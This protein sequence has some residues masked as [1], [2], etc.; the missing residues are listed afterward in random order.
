TDARRRHI[1][2]LEK[3]HGGV[4]FLDE[5]GEIDPATQIKLLRFLE[6]HEF[7]RLGSTQS[8][9]IDVQ[10][11]AATNANL[12][13]RVR[14]GQFRRDLYFRL[15]VHE[16][17]LPPL[18]DR[19]ED[20]PPLV[21]YALQLLRQRGKQVHRISPEAMKAL[22]RFSWPGNV[23]QLKNVIEAAIFQA[24]LHGHDQIAV[25]D[26]PADVRNEIFQ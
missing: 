19:P 13:E 16:I 1:G 20:V 4:L 25:E 24:E 9:K 10:I 11:I 23:R 12:E 15:K 14:D 6:E 2:Y 5:I 8:I 3:A 7:Q 22:R 26:L 21:E 18:K 17:V